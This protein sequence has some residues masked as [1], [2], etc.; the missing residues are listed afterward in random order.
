MTGFHN[1]ANAPKNVTAEEGYE[2][3]RI[4]EITMK[5]INKERKRAVRRIIYFVA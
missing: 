2:G 5:T 4:Q 1:S 3:K